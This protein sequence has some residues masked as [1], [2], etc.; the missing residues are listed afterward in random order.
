MGSSFLQVIDSFSY[1][2][3]VLGNKCSHEHAN[4]RIS[5]CRK[6]FHALQAVGLCNT[7]LN[8]HTA[9]YVWSSTYKSILT[10]GCDALY[11]KNN[12]VMDLDQIQ[13]N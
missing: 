11:L 9:L 13:G 3:A 12:D 10:Y 7:G 8:I 6:A 1:L 5:A 4:N 2:G